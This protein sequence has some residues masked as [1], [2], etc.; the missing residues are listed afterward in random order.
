MAMC[1]NVHWKPAQ[2]EY[3]TVHIKHAIVRHAQLWQQQNSQLWYV[4]QLATHIA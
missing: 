4:G 3:T 1:G 2:I